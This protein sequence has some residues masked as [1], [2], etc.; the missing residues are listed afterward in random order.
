[1]PDQHAPA[2]RRQDWL[3]LLA[4]WA[5]AVA[6]LM[7]RVYS[8]GEGPL[9]ADTDDAMRMVVVRDLLAGQG[10]YDLVQ[11][12]LNIP[13]GAEIHWSRLIDVPLA[14]MVALFSLITT[15]ANA[16]LLAGTIWPLAL[17]AVVLWLSA[18]ITLEIVGRD[19]LLP[20]LVLPVLSPAIL[21]EFNPGRVDHHNVIILLTLAALWTVL[22][23]LRRPRFAIGAGL[24]IATGMGV[25]VESLPVVIA[26][27]LAIGLFYVFD[28]VHKRTLGLFGAAFAVGMWANLAIVRP[29]SRWLEAACDMISPVYVL[30]GFAIGAAYI[31]VAALPTPRA[32]WQRLGL[33]AVLGLAAAYIVALVYPQ[34]LAGPYGQLDPWLQTHWLGAISEAKTWHVA[35]REM[36]GYALSVGI[37]ALLAL[38]I[39]AIA[40]W[41]EPG[42]RQQWL[43]LLVFLLLLNIVMLAQ[44]R[45][46][47]LAVIPAMPAAAWLIVS[48]RR[49]YL[50]RPSVL[51]ALGL[52]GS[53]LAFSGVI[54]AILVVVTSNAFPGV[55]AGIPQ[56]DGNKRACLATSA[57]VDLAPLPPERIMTPID[58]GAH[59]LLE[60]DH[61]V[62]SAPYHRNQQ[63]V[64]DTFAFFN[65]PV[66]GAKA[67]AADRGLGLRVTC[68]TMP[69]MAGQADRAKPAL[70]DL[71]R[72][73]DLPEWLVDVSLEGPLRVYAI[74]P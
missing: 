61:A 68:P 51:P 49:V 26:A 21:A 6:T 50:A 4:I 70:V 73:G 7:L 52:L 34:C 74:L 44:I 56:N 39:A 64:L 9:F 18:R 13:Y 19:G 25:A 71:L 47:R 24:V 20:A 62:V 29:P 22:V 43:T 40:F 45:G 15:Q 23:S 54:I 5:V 14:A 67:I 41:R 11:H 1:M 28:P 60:T 12:R 17:L 65:G 36:P 16:M 8:R 27:V 72:D 66:D 10:W 30:A 33:L 35:L 48:V 59:M 46:A 32:A 55:V 53:W 42:K 63:G 38:V 37:P 58:L 31:V 3:W 2:L 69:E 57:F